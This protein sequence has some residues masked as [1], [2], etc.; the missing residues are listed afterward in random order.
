MAIISLR[1]DRRLCIQNANTTPQDIMNNKSVDSRS[2]IDASRS[3]NPFL[4]KLNEFLVS[5]HRFWFKF[6]TEFQMRWLIKQ[7]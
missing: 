1:T 7:L 2:Y 3:M 6:L 5:S 4:E